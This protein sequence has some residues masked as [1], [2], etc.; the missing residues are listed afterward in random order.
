MAEQAP[1][2]FIQTTLVHPTKV[3]QSISVIFVPLEEEPFSSKGGLS[4]T[5]MC[6]ELG[7]SPDDRLS[8]D[9]KSSEVLTEFFNLA[10]SEAPAAPEPPPPDLDLGDPLSLNLKIFEDSPAEYFSKLLLD[11]QVIVVEQSPPTIT[12]LAHLLSH[13]SGAVAIGAYLGFQ[14]ATG[15]ILLISVPAGMIVCGAASGIAAGLQQW[16]GARI[17]RLQLR[18]RRKNRPGPTSPKQKPQSRSASA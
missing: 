13:K 2:R 15:P 4:A 10:L 11:E 9:I 12:T 5:E 6:G 18:R 17:A 8:T 1:A 14:I 16:L 3:D 7:V